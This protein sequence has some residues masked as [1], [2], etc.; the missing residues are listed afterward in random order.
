MA[1]V[2]L[3]ANFYAVR[4]QLAKSN[5]SGKPWS[6]EQQVIFDW[7][8]F[9]SGNLVVRARAGCGKTSTLIEGINRAPERRILLAAF[10]KIIAEELQN[11]ITNPNARAQTLHALGMTFCRRHIAGLEVDTKGER[12]RFLARKAIDALSAGKPAAKNPSFNV[13]ATVAG[14]HTKIRE[15]LVDPVADIILAGLSASSPL[16]PGYWNERLESFA[17]DFGFEGDESAFWTTP[18]VVEAALNCIEFAKEPTTTIDFADMIFLPLVHGWATP[19]CDLLAVDE[20]QDVTEAQLRLAL[21]SVSE[22]GRIC[23]CGDEKQAIYAFRGADSE[24]LDRLKDELS[25]D[26]L[27]LKTTYRCPRSVVELAQSFVPDFVAAPE[28]PIGEVTNLKTTAQLIRLA[29]PGDFVLSRVNADLIPI[30]L[31]LIRGGKKAYVRGKEFGREALK[32]L[33]KLDAGSLGRLSVAL[34]K[35]RKREEKK[36]G[37][38]STKAAQAKLF[39]I[40]ENCAVLEAFIEGSKNLIDLRD[41]IEAAFTD[42]PHPDAIA[43][44]TVHKAKGLEAKRVFLLADSFSRETGEEEN[45]C[46]VAVTRAKGV[47]YIHG[48]TV[49]EFIKGL[50]VPLWLK[51]Q[52]VR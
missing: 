50:R 7:F 46:Y 40:N 1:L 2:E 35:W 8:E 38:L 23:I 25:A 17:I 27:G 36:L 45:I 51:D 13:V 47:L 37:D 20:A 14:L 39:R 48:R 5:M 31:E 21:A 30:C 6:L 34:V 28:A 12:A 15:I 9:G 10:N 22:T 43:C 52:F 32:L 11:R 18:K 29:E 44:S 26:E 4:D 16:R 19:V 49:S 3:P 24:S 41:K 42:N 33:D